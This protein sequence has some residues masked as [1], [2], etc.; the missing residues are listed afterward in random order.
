MFSFFFFKLSPFETFHYLF[1]AC[2]QGFQW[3][4]S[5]HPPWSFPDH[6]GRH[7]QIIP[8]LSVCLSICLLRLSVYLTSWESICLNAALLA[9]HLHPKPGC[10][11][12]AGPPRLA[13]M[14]PLADDLPCWLPGCL[15]SCL[16][17]SCSDRPT[18]LDVTACLDSAPLFRH[19]NFTCSRW[20]YIPH[21]QQS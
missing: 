7:S 15:L 12:P 18:C 10:L 5:C 9:A 6:T 21:R 17:V 3:H 4:T 1:P 20:S 2:H 11:P 8:H 16:S 13:A 14:S 19:E